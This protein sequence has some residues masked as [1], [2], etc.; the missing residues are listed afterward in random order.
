MYM[1]V[2]VERK[3]RARDG[4]SQVGEANTTAHLSVVCFFASFRSFIAS[5]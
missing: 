2:G 4:V 1:L 5:R 3:Y